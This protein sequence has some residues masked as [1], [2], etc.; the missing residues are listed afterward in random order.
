MWNYWIGGKDHFAADREAA[1]L[2]ETDDILSAAASTLDFS[3]PVA[4]L[5]LAVLHFIPDADD[6]YAIVRKLMDAVPSWSSS[7]PR[8][9]A[10]PR[11]WRSTPALQR[12]GRRVH[13]PAQPGGDPAVLHRPRAAR[14]RRR[15][16][17][18][19]AA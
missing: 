8:A 12:V 17:V 18:G 5:L 3:E 2:R 13:A 15:A 9:I 10:V 11:R 4:I 19:V 16:A 14:A 1:D 7:T 6:P